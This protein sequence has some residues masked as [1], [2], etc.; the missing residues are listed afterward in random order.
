MVVSQGF[1]SIWIQPSLLCRLFSGWCIDLDN[2]MQRYLCFLLLW[3]MC[4]CLIK[5][6]V[7][8][9]E[10]KSFVFFVA[11]A[12]TPFSWCFFNV[13]L[14]TLDSTRSFILCSK[15]KQ[16]DAYLALKKCFSVPSIGWTAVKPT[17]H[18]SAAFSC[19]YN[20]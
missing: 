9:L 17:V 4:L 10:N 3:G 18:K 14:C 7:I 13:L 19:L 16:K 5:Q 15:M 11:T 20:P 8:H 12:R 6:I 2:W 1:F